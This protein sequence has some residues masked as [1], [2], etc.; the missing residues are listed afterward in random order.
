MSHKMEEKE[1][2]IVEVFVNT[3]AE[4]GAT[5]FSVKRGEKE[6]IF[7]KHVLK[8]SPAA[9]QLRMREG[10]QLISATIYFDNVKYEDALKILQY[11]E[12]YK[13][14]YCL[15]RT[16]Y[17]T[18]GSEAV[19]VK[20]SK[21]I[22]GAEEEFFSTLYGNKTKITR[23][24]SEE[25]STPAE[26]QLQE[27]TQ[28]GRTKAA[29]VPDVTF[30]CPKFPAFKK[31]KTYRLD[32]SHSLSETEEREQHDVTA[33]STD[34]ESH[35]KTAETAEKAKKRRRKIKL[36]HI[37][38]GGIKMGKTED[39]EQERREPVSGSKEL[40]A[41]KYEKFTI[42]A[43]SIAQNTNGTA[44]TAI[45]QSDRKLEN[46]SNAM[47]SD[48]INR[49]SKLKMPKL[50]I[51]KFILSEPIEPT[52]D[53]GTK[54]PDEQSHLQTSDTNMEQHKIQIDDSK[55]DNNTL[56][57]ILTTASES[58][59][60][61]ASG[62]TKAKS[63]IEEEYAE[64][65][66][67]QT[68]QV[69]S[70]K[71]PSSIHVKADV[72]LPQHEE[73]ETSVS[74]Q[75]ADKSFP[76]SG[77]E[78]KKSKTDKQIKS[79][80]TKKKE[81]RGKA[82]EKETKSSTLAIGVSLTKIDAKDSKTDR[83]NTDRAV[84]TLPA[85]L[86]GNLTTRHTEPAEV[87]SI[88]EISKREQRIEI[89]GKKYQTHEREQDWDSYQTK[90]E[91]NMEIP[92]MQIK[93]GQKIEKSKTQGQALV[94]SK[95][96]KEH[97]KMN[98]DV[99]LPK[100]DVSQ[101]KA[102]TYV[103]AASI[104]VTTSKM[105]GNL[106]L[107]EIDIKGP[108]VGLR[109]P[110]VEK[111]E[112]DT[113]MPKVMDVDVSMPKTD[114]DVSDLGM[115]VDIKAP[116]TAIQ[117]PT[118]D[119]D[120]DSADQKVKGDG[121]KFKMPSVKMPSFGIYLPKF[122]GPEVDVSKPDIDISVE[123][124][125]VDMKDAKMDISTPKFEADL[126]AL[127]V[128][129]EEKGRKIE[130]PKYKAP[131]FGFSTPDIHAPKMGQD[132]NLPKV[133]VSQS[134][135]DMDAK[136][137]SVDVKTG[138]LEGD[139]SL[140]K[141]DIKGPDFELKMPE[142]E[143]PQFDIEMR[144]SK[145][146]VDVDV[147]IPK[148]DIE[149]SAPKM[150]VGLK[151]P[152]TEVDLPTVDVGLESGDMKM[153]S[154]GGKFKLPSVKMPSFG[155]S[156]P[157]FKG[158]EIDVSA[159]KP[160]VD[161]SVENPEIHLKGP[162]VDVSATEL[163]ADLPGPVVDIEGKVGKIKFP[164]FKLPKLGFSASDKN[165]PMKDFNVHLPKVDVSLPK[166]DLDVKL[167]SADVLPENAVDRINVAG[168]DMQCPNVTL[169][170]PE[171][172]K[173]T[174]DNEVPKAKGDLDVNVSMPKPELGVSTPGMSV[175]IKAPS[176]DV[177]LPTVDVHLD[178]AD[179]KMKDDGAK[180]EMPPMKLPSF[181]VSVPKLKGP[182]V[183]MSVSQPDVDIS[184]E[185]PP[186]DS[187]GLKIDLIAPECEGRI[188]AGDITI[189][190]KGEK[191]NIPKFKAT[192]FGVLTPEMKPLKTNVDINVSP[193]DISRSKTALVENERNIDVKA[194]T[195][196]V[197]NN[198]AAFDFK[199]VDAHLKM[200][201]IQSSQISI[202]DPKTKGKIDAETLM[203]KTQLDV[204]A[205][206]MSVD[207]KAPALFSV[208]FSKFKFPDVDFRT[209]TTGNDDP[210][211]SKAVT[212][213]SG[214]S[215]QGKSCEHSDKTAPELKGQKDAGLTATE[216]S[217]PSKGRTSWFKFPKINFSSPWKKEK[218]ADGEKQTAHEIPTSSTE[219]IKPS[220]KVADVK[221]DGHDFLP[222]GSS[223]EVS[224][225]TI[226]TSKEVTVED[227]ENR[228]TDDGTTQ[229]VTMKSK[230]PGTVVGGTYVI[231][232][233][234]VVTSTARTELALLESGDFRINVQSSKTS[235]SES[236]H[237][238]QVPTCETSSE[239]HQIVLTG[240][241]ITKANDKQESTKKS[242]I[243]QSSNLPISPPPEGIT[244]THLTEHSTV[245]TKETLMQEQAASGIAEPAKSTKE[246]SESHLPKS[247]YTVSAKGHALTKKY[248]RTEGTVVV[249][250]DSSILQGD[251]A[252]G[253]TVTDDTSTVFET[254]KEMIQ[255][256]QKQFSEKSQLSS[257]SIPISESETKEIKK[258]ETKE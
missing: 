11:S 43:D 245:V 34:I 171:K 141:I 173:P 15:K 177:D 38:A 219:P 90:S 109:I 244:R 240:T 48:N 88:T 133:D 71:Q 84:K 60:K 163:E 239:S 149:V 81:A 179:L 252:P 174:I 64:V 13:M 230:D 214:Q 62:I 192:K 57:A 75:V 29:E 89:S 137:P 105:E 77:K 258:T 12:P 193:V 199:Q 128:D 124:P 46:Q 61:T 70:Q 189:A 101:T 232:P 190:G 248:T 51:A 246:L 18:I 130:L 150:S 120:L 234:Q 155:I 35:L 39:S 82:S 114:I 97:V 169:K 44:T 205:P 227:T 94:S 26:A 175:D 184:A 139:L 14:K 112:V 183:D 100:V 168:I 247:E 85:R 242:G 92:R 144:K 216:E 152:S 132:V 9:K 148:T 68:Q 156:L 59:L 96:D 40:S 254:M 187:R 215:L 229:I 181:G 103:K 107:G 225:S 19:E 233:S 178:S 204:S 3:E 23:D 256:E 160:D 159:S 206:E 121:G 74:K 127:D 86:L 172:K 210:D 22:V 50:K 185:K 162:K 21:P 78:T 151:A 221:S 10:D 93:G 7:I 5:G 131:K 118:V 188:E 76:K 66:G 191:F 158:P 49:E 41:L 108:D 147:S 87:D 67:Q 253:A 53:V 42:H 226:P 126:Q 249:L 180:L 213:E 182:E 73:Q 186:I 138:K 224:P 58:N 211:F 65:T 20:G 113:E 212:K 251:I 203:P 45:K 27:A 24:G 250:T 119:M 241:K 165:A 125:E 243:P 1:K 231:T 235:K 164:T 110:E 129:I 236:S 63:Q 102:D 95:P 197:H 145:G 170:M 153:K 91:E 83:D 72:T 223:D 104:D 106:S 80:K 2:D 32:R 54:L 257:V 122:K 222:G 135:A 198:V 146:K 194:G 207:I 115:S 136:V 195:V 218:A 31:T 202:G 117:I 30:S 208:S 4:V 111:P 161:I 56:S 167:A 79:K 33:T 8:E 47:E 209:E 201:G 217:S 16:I 25:M 17:D 176:T 36:P 220:V 52:T 116:S 142:V 238:G 28:K 196:E 98:D 134:K 157:K 143:K 69:V 55:R 255:N 166:A 6:G 228:T 123:K 99:N 140:G 237:Q 37:G 154:D 200:P